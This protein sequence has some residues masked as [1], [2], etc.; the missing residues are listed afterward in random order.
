MSDQKQTG[1]SG[2]LDRLECLN[3]NRMESLKICKK[4]F[5]GGGGGCIWKIASA[6]VPFL[7]FEMSDD[8]DM[9]NKDLRS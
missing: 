9:S 4:L 3:R 1:V 2:D 5:V 8:I 6:P 7:R